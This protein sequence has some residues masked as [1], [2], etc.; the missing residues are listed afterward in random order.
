MLD[1]SFSGIYPTSKTK[2]GGRTKQNFKNKNKNLYPYFTQETKSKC[3]YLFPQYEK[4]TFQK[5]S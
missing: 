1:Q 4:S 5:Q 2:G 3:L